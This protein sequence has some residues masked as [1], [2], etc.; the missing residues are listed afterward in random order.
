MGYL[1]SIVI[2][3]FVFPEVLPRLELVVVMCFMLSA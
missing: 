1:I 2:G 3:V